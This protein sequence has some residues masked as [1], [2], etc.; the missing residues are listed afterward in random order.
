MSD[1][2]VI[3]FLQFYSTKTLEPIRQEEIEEFLGNLQKYI[4]AAFVTLDK[5]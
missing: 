1:T 5:K 4:N 3:P 2:G